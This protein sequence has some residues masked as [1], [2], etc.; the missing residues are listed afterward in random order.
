MCLQV[1]LQCLGY[2]QRTQ[3]E[4]LSLPLLTA[5]YQGLVAAAVW[6]L[7]CLARHVLVPCVLSEAEYVS[8]KVLQAVQCQ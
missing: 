5:L 7:P 4:C 8:T 6:S 1:V 3:L 2:R